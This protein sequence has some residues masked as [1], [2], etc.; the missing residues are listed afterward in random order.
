MAGEVNRIGE[1]AVFRDVDIRGID[2]NSEFMYKVKCEE[3]LLRWWFWRLR[4]RI[5]ICRVMSLQISFKQILTL[6][7]IVRSVASSPV[8][9]SKQTGRHKSICMTP[10]HQT[11]NFKIF[12]WR[13]HVFPC[14]SSLFEHLFTASWSTSR[15]LRKSSMICAKIHHTKA[16]VKRHRFNQLNRN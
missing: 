8:K 15:S 1:V 12:P 11:P 9:L 16:I 4:L 13:S 5:L 3:N 2:M 10:T 14:V 6:F 7:Y